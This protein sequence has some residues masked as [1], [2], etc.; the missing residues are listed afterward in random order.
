MRRRTTTYNNYLDNRRPDQACE[1]SVIRGSVLAI[2]LGRDNS[3]PMITDGSTAAEHATL[4]VIGDTDYTP[5]SKRA[6]S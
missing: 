4:H 2:G 1:E 6:I 5:M 3:E